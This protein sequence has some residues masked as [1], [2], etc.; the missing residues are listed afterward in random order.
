MGPVW[1]YW[2]FPMEQLCG[3]LGRANLNPRYPFVSMDC[4]V[5]EVA[6]LAQ[7]KYM[8]N[9]FEMLDLGDHTQA[10]AKGTCY[11]AY[12][13]SIFVRPRCVIMLNSSLARQLGSYIGE[14]YDVDSKA[15]ERHI[16]GRKFNV[17]AK[18]QLTCDMNG[19]KMVTGHAFMPDTETPRRDTTYIKVFSFHCGYLKSPLILSL[20]LCSMFSSGTVQSVDGPSMLQKAP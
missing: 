5:L 3:A 1:C 16:K 4:R 17:W 9:L 8:Y 18:M 10:L 7:I 13:A 6:Q 20:S 12:P 11:S 14:M 15:V 19:L 2:A